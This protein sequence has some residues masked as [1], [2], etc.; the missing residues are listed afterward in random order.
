[1]G[2]RSI[3]GSGS[4]SPACAARFFSKLCIVNKSPYIECV[5]GKAP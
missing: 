2:S 5:R 4:L 3:S 1:M